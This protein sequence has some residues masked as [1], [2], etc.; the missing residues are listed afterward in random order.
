MARDTYHEAVKKALVRDGWTITHD[1][2]TLEFGSRKLYVDLGAELPIGAERDGETIAV[3]VKS[4]V[5]PSDMLD[6]ERALGQFVL[7]GFLLGRQDPDRT[8]YLAVT[9]DTYDAVF[10]EPEGRD[11][12]DAEQV[13]L[14]VFDVIEEAI[15][16]WFR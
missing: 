6:L 9:A 14:I 11:L 2:L 16:R 3:E 10:N 1:P 13:R 8:L 12:I 15:I 4:F 5:G 7:Y